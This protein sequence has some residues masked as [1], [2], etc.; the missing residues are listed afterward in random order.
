MRTLENWFGR[1]RKLLPPALLTVRCDRETFYDYRAFGACLRAL[2]NDKRRF[3]TGPVTQLS[4]RGSLANLIAH[5]E[6][7][8]S[9]ETRGHVARQ[10]DAAP[11]SSVTPRSIRE[12]L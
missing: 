3:G 7:R 1:D 8:A 2:L 6:E 10:F 12:A 4:A 11:D 5:V 9:G